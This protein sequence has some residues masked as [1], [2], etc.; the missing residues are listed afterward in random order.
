MGGEG[1]GRRRGEQR[2]RDMRGRGGQ[3]LWG[4]SELRGGRG[5]EVGR[6]RG[7]VERSGEEV[8]IESP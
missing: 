1:A 2:R 7:G 5:E 3:E 8:G 4:E 6:R